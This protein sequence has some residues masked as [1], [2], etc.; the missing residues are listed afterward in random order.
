MAVKI[1]EIWRQ[2]QKIDG[3]KSSKN[4][5]KWKKIR[6]KTDEKKI[7]EEKIEELKKKGR[8]ALKEKKVEELKN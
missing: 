2:K 5:K 1:S 8:N 6:K 4:V 7:E 3:E